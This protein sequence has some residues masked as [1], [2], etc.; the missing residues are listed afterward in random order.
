MQKNQREIK[1]ANRINHQKWSRNK[2][3]KFWK[4]KR[5]RKFKEVLFNE[6]ILKSE[7]ENYET[8]IKTSNNKLEEVE[9]KSEEKDTNLNY[10]HPNPADS[11]R[12]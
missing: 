4:K 5:K 3:L 12:N 8:R 1:T 9:E 6:W 7:V 11:W 2:L 10:Y